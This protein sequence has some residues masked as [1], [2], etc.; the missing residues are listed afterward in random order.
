M[1]GSN[2]NATKVTEVTLYTTLFPRYVI[3]RSR[4]R[5]CHH[6][7]A[8]GK[9]SSVFSLGCGKLTGAQR[10]KYMVTSYRTTVSRTQHSGSARIPACLYVIY[11]NN[12]DTI[13][14]SREAFFC[15]SYTYYCLN[16]NNKIDKCN[17][18]SQCSKELIGWLVQLSVFFEIKKFRSTSVTAR[19]ISVHPIHCFS[20]VAR[21]PIR[22]LS[23]FCEP[24]AFLNELKLMFPILYR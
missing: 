16:V 20:R 6:H 9:N 2:P 10:R 12:T 1:A 23:Y 14:I 15:L 8:A 5:S 13:V 19:N 18:C 11:D 21:S 22:R 24:Q 4:H 7:G 3:S 17:I